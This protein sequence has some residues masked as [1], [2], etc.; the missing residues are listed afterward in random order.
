MWEGKWQW[1]ARPHAQRCRLLDMQAILRLAWR[2]VGART[3]NADLQ[4]T[5]LLGAPM[6]TSYLSRR[7]AAGIAAAGVAVLPLL[8]AAA[9]DAIK[10]GAPLP[11]TGPLSPEGLKQKR[12]YDLWVE[13]ANTKG[14][15]K[16]GGKTYT[17]EIVYTDYAS[18]TP[19]AVQSAERMITDDKVNFLFAPFGSGATKAASAVS[20]KYGIPMIAPTASSA[21]VYDQSYKFLFGTLTPNETVSEPIARLVT[22]KNP[23]IKRV[24]IL[25]RN[26][27]FP[28]AVGAGVR[29]GREGAESRSGDVRA[30][31]DWNDGSCRG[32]HANA[33]GASRLGLCVGLY[34]R[35]H[36]HP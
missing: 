6:F 11:L 3:I 7:V 20:E 22:E 12:G 1:T 21:E 4:S 36:P 29:E 24:A 18:N 26:D 17:V 5:R 8:P 10:V 25:A 31:R 9:Q 30:L 23:N 15:I 32:D 35:S 27:L 28:L 34:Q 14:G 33:R 19:R 16:A 2:N 13:T